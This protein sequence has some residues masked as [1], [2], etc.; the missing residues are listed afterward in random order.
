MRKIHAH[1][2]GKNSRRL[3][4]DG[5]VIA[6]I[7]CFL[8]A[9][10]LGVVWGERTRGGK[11]SVTAEDRAYATAETVPPEGDTSAPDASIND[12]SGASLESGGHAEPDGGGGV[13]SDGVDGVLYAPVPAIIPGTLAF[14]SETATTVFSFGPAPT[15]E[16]YPGAR[17]EHRRLGFVM[18][19]PTVFALEGEGSEY[20]LLSNRRSGSPAYPREGDLFFRVE[21]GSCGAIDRDHERFA[22]P[23]CGYCM[24]GSPPPD[25]V[26]P[27]KKELCVP[28]FL[29]RL[30]AASA[31]EAK[32]RSLERFLD[33]V[34]LTLYP[35]VSATPPYTPI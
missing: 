9:I 18:H 27:H 17:Y 4:V 29:L 8:F 21:R 10:F 3:V 5:V 19:L 7:L 24:D 16:D 2:D 25:W 34:A 13:S 31:E 26:L 15:F 33:N 11:E 12:R 6:L 28:P 14:P 32:R 30:T 23:S 1:K 35:I 20:V 22:A